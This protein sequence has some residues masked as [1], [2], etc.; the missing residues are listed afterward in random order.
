MKDDPTGARRGAV[1]VVAALVESRAQDGSARVFL[2]RRSEAAG[3]GGLWELPGG[4]VEPGEKAEAAIRREIAEELGVGIEL[5]GPPRLYSSRIAERAF[6]FLVFPASFT[7]EGEERFDLAAHD[8][9]AYFAPQALAS[10]SLAPLDGPALDEWARS[11]LRAR[12]SLESN[13]LV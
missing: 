3:H 1:T 2:A 11:S 4:K 9:W 8:A 6:D 5:L 13:H 7:A 10:L 12:R